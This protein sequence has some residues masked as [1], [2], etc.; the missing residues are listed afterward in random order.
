[1]ATL[2]HPALQPQKAPERD[3]QGAGDNNLFHCR[4][5]GIWHTAGTR[6]HQSMAGQNPYRAGTHEH[7][8]WDAHHLQPAQNTVYITD[9][10]DSQEPAADIETATVDLTRDDSE[11]IHKP[12]PEDFWLS[13]GIRAHR[14]LKKSD[15]M[16]LQSDSEW[17]TDDIINAFIHLCIEINTGLQPNRSMF[18]LNPSIAAA[19]TFVLDYQRDRRRMYY[20]ITD[21][22]KSVDYRWSRA[23]H[24]I[25]LYHRYII[26]VNLVNSHW[27]TALIDFNKR[28]ICL[29]DSIPNDKHDGMTFSKI[30]AVLNDAKNIYD[31]RKIINPFFDTDFSTFEKVRDNS[32]VEQKD[33]HNCGVFT[34]I[35]IERLFFGG[36]LQSS[37]KDPEKGIDARNARGYRDHIIDMFETYKNESGSRLFRTGRMLSMLLLQ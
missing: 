4:E 15:R 12:S 37:V 32:F 13:I 2:S 9:S 29:F 7:L 3:L 26:P 16:I 33:G 1:M 11:P 27:L 19:D 31:E 6:Q 22:N 14:V 20:N 23:S 35:A 36:S 21:L 17:L 18:T 10:Q 30:I 8:N 34:C 28:E 24:N 5:A 25:A